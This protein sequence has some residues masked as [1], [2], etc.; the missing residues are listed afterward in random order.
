MALILG[1]TRKSKFY[2]NDIPVQ[3]VSTEGFKKIVLEVLGKRY[4]V[5]DL[6]SVE[7]YPE[8]KVS[9]GIP[10]AQ[11]KVAEYE[12]LP[13]LVIDAPKTILILREELYDRKDKT[14]IPNPSPCGT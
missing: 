4:T 5:S 11:H 12:A 2:L 9:C 8:V 6:E 13:R 1:V 7:I 14:R 10:S 3:V